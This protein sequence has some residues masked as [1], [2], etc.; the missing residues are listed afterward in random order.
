MV[1]I[2]P[3]GIKIM[4]KLVLSLLALFRLCSWTMADPVAMQFTNG[5]GSQ[6]IGGGLIGS[7]SVNVNVNGTIT[8]EQLW[9]DDYTSRL[10]WGQTWSA[11]LTSLNISGGT[12]TVTGNLDNTKFNSSRGTDYYLQSAWILSQWGT[13]SFDN[14]VL[15]G[16][17]WQLSNNNQPL[18]DSGSYQGA[19]NTV[20]FQAAAA[21]NSRSVW[22]NLYIYTPADPLTGAAI[23]KIGE[24]YTQE[25]IKVAPVPEPSS[26]L[27][28]G[29][30]MVSLALFSRQKMKKG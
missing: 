27:L 30:G 14:I 26:L 3:K 15:Q 13:G 11:N 6:A 12:T 23:A 5:T 9:C 22:G 28:L 20:L 17:L 24:N 18:S 4:K 19:I 8:P 2:H 29:S 16:A 21:V 10:N 25:L 1:F 7:Y